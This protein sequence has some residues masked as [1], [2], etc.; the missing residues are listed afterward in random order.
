MHAVIF[1]AAVISFLHTAPPAQLLKKALTNII[2]SEEFKIPSPLAASARKAAT[3]D[4]LV[5]IK[6]EENGQKIELFAND[7]IVQL[8]RTFCCTCS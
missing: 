6:R 2:V 7:V 8:K 1:S 3:D 4:L 5:W